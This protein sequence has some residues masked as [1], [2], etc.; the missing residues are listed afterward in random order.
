MRI[1]P[2]LGHRWRSMPLAI[3]ALALLIVLGG[4]GV[5]W[6]SE[7]GALLY[8]ML[9]FALGGVTERWQFFLGLILLGVVS[10]IALAITSVAAG[11]VF[12]E[13]TRLDVAPTTAAGVRDDY[14][15]PAGSVRLDLSQVADPEALD[16]RSIDVTANAGELRVIVP[17]DVTVH[18][19]ADVQVG[20]EADVAGSYEAGP[21][22]HVNRTIDAGPSAPEI[23]LDL[24]LLVGS[25]EVRQS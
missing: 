8:V 12:D 16:G 24:S 19:D 1:L 22:V 3:F 21:D 20:G 5:I 7:R 4:V 9:E 15:V 11:P 6:Q 23:D 17:D 2:T 18:V 13:G 25:I 10:A 14:S